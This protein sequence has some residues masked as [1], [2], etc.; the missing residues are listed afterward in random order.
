[1]NRVVHLVT[2]SYTTNRYGVMEKSQTMRKVFA[3]I[4]SVTG[5][6][7]FEGGRNGLNPEFRVRVKQCEYKG[8]EILVYHGIFYT[9]YRTY[10]D[11]DMTELYVEK[12]K[13]N[14][15]I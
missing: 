2:E 3:E 14:D 8:E 10:L 13:G 1:M 12:R 15:G 5:R 6:E 7:W 11:G 4:G 9:I